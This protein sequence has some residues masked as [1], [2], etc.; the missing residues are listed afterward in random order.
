MFMSGHESFDASGKKQFADYCGHYGIYGQTMYHKANYWTVIP[1]VHILPPIASSKKLAMQ[2]AG[3][4][5]L[6]IFVASS[7]GTLKVSRRTGLRF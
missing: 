4:L 1:T 7:K 2:F 3:N 6:D 5:L